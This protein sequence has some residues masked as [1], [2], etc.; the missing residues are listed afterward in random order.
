MT[1]M[2]AVTGQVLW[3]IAA[4]PIVALVWIGYELSRIANALEKHNGDRK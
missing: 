1:A 3:I 2:T 4:P